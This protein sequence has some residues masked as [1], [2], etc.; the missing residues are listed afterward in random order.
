MLEVIQRLLQEMALMTQLE[1]AAV[2]CALAYVLLAMKQ[3]LWCWPA[4]LLSSGLY[5]YILWQAALL[6]DAL[7]QFYYVLMALYGWFHWQRLQ[8]QA[9]NSPEAQS[10][11][12]ELS[13]TVHA[14]LI[15]V[16]ALF[17]GLLGYVMATY[18]HA[19]YAWVDAQTT[20]FSVMATFLVAR[21]VLSNWLYFVVIDAVSVYIYSQK[22]LYLTC[23][24][25]V[26]YTV[27]ALAGFYLWRQSY[28][29]QQAN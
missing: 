18:T 28:L 2:L 4:A 23:A 6:S 14:R 10:L 16:T 20:A 17:G 7:L 8:N 15:F 26:L 27:I 19:D 1:I 11:V 24:L 22:S 21:K 29:K 25:F 13:L 9:K 3:S 12:R 5:T